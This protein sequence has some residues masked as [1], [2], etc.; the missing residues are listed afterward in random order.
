MR[1][2]R[3]PSLTAPVALQFAELPLWIWASLPKRVVSLVYFEI[4]RWERKTTGNW[5]NTA[6]RLT[7][8]VLSR[9]IIFCPNLGVLNRII[10]YLF[11]HVG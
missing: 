5:R 3:C 6:G 4:T 2:W 8:S 9:Y 11:V 1:A 10:F 7:V